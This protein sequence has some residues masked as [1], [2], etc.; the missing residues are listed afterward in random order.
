[1][2]KCQL[3]AFRFLTRNLPM[4]ARL[5]Q[6]ISDPMLALRFVE[7]D[8]G[9]AFADLARPD[10]DE[11]MDADDESTPE[12]NPIYPYNS[13]RTPLETLHDAGPQ[14]ILFPASGGPR[15]I[16]LPTL[17][18]K[19]IDPYMLRDERKRIIDGRIQQRIRELESLPALLPDGS[20]NNEAIASQKIR[21]L[22][23]LKSLRLLGKQKA[24]RD[25]VVRGMAQ[26]TQLS[27]TSDR[28]AF[29]RVRKPTLQ[30]AKTIESWERKQKQERDRR[31]RQKHL[32]R[33][34]AVST[35]GSE[36]R[37]AQKSHKEVLQ[38]LGKLVQK[39]HADT[40]R[41]ESRRIERVSKERLKALRADDE[42]AYLKLIDKTKDTR[43]THL[44][45]QTDAYLDGLAQA[46]VSQQNDASVRDPMAVD[47]Q[48]ADQSGAAIDEGEFGA[49][50]VFEEEE[51]TRVDYYNVAH[52]IKETVSVQPSILN[53]GT[54]KEYQLKG[55][56]WMI[57]LYNNRLNG[58]LA[59]E[60][61]RPRPGLSRTVPDGIARRDLA[62]RSSRSRSSATSWRSSGCRAHSSSLSR[63][64]P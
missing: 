17:L 64:R 50:P 23:E 29:R 41:E 14:G 7:E 10:A 63:S 21:A 38:R 22:I 51:K 9:K 5:Q 55:L 52:A 49:A 45:R 37:A 34:L 58:I 44:I 42:E 20:S 31:M 16:V 48:R 26:A 27:L 3:A 25:T 18:P 33:L 19:G 8:D 47:R 28:Q 40:E 35:H 46:V 2:L 4:P 1:M 62:R 43:I 61:V 32:D 60:M 54:L 57:S 30:D 11:I 24:L 56:Q 39:F 13:F 12:T 53:G 15:Q 6:A 36:L 59:D